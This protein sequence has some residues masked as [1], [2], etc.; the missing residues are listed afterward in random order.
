MPTL[1]VPFLVICFSRTVSSVPWWGYVCLFFPDHRRRALLLCCLIK[2]EMD[3][4]SWMQLSY[5]PHWQ[6]GYAV[7]A[8]GAVVYI[9]RRPSPKCSVYTP[10]QT[11]LPQAPV[12][13]YCTSPPFLSAVYH[14]ASISPTS[15]AHASVLVLLDRE[16]HVH[17]KRLVCRVLSWRRVAMTNVPPYHAHVRTALFARRPKCRNDEDR[18]CI[19]R[20]GTDLRNRPCCEGRFFCVGPGSHVSAA[21]SAHSWPS[22]LSRPTGLIHDHHHTLARQGGLLENDPKGASDMYAL[23]F[24]PVDSLN[25]CAPHVIMYI[26]I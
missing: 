14:A 4:A 25:T 6:S 15:K 12:K 9:S 26:I 24:V 13:V 20:P 21:S 3:Y 7:R 10:C 16:Q 2:P 23:L 5:T 19:I 18:V 11:L 22:P 1:P 17:P 8:V